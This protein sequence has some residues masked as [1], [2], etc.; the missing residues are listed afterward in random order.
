MWHGFDLFWCWSWLVGGSKKVFNSVHSVDKVWVDEEENPFDK[1]WENFPPE[2]LADHCGVSDLFY[3]QRYE[4]QE[5][6]NPWARLGP[7]RKVSQATNIKKNQ[8]LGPK[9]PS[10]CLL[11][12]VGEYSM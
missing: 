6:D 12:L 9:P 4:E 1:D 10:Y 2:E 8:A 7:E 3:W 5:V 11:G